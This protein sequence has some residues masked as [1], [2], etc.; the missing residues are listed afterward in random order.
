MQPDRKTH[1]LPTPAG[2][3]GF[4]DPLFLV[5]HSVPLR[6]RPF[7]LSR[8]FRYRSELLGRIIT[9]PS[10]YRTDFASIPRVFWRVLHPVGAYSHAAVIH[11]WLCDLR[12]STGIDSRTAHAIFE[13]AMG[14]LGVAAWKRWV[15]VRG[16]QVFGPRF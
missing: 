15:M 4:L 2:A 13:E 16:V 8:S 14:T 5:A 10:G 12:G 9:V 7:E 1:S 3:G 6:E 11:D